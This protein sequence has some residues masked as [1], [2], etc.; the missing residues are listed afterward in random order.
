MPHSVC[1]PLASSPSAQ[2]VIAMFKIV[3][4]GFL[5]YGCANGQALPFDYVE[6]RGRKLLRGR[7][8]I[9]VKD[10][11]IKLSIE[12]VQV[13]RL[14][15]AESEGCCQI[16]AIEQ[17]NCGWDHNDEP[18]VADLRLY[19]KLRY[20]LREVLHQFEDIGS[21]G[22]SCGYDVDRRGHVNIE[23]VAADESAS[24]TNPCS[25]AHMLANSLSHAVYDNEMTRLFA[26]VHRVLVEN[27]GVS[28]AR[29]YYEPFLQLE[30]TD[31][32]LI[33]GGHG[34]W[35]KFYIDDAGQRFYVGCEPESRDKFEKAIRATNDVL[36]PLA[37]KYFALR[38]SGID[39]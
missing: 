24:V 3:G 30:P 34:G 10:E 33:P 11:R 13:E 4:V 37:A 5:D 22:Y 18:T 31:E 6:D 15:L 12:G 9:Y 38:V 39:C 7:M 21:V 8:I 23:L 2:E 16:V 25:F 17:Q 32:L 29:R 28:D 36:N 20:A 26:L 35:M 19:P 27:L 1:L 14:T